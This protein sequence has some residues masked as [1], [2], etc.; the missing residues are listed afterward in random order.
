[1]R[2]QGGL[3][4]VFC[5]VLKWQRWQ[6]VTWRLWRRTGCHAHLGGG[7]WRSEDPAS[8][9]AGSGALPCSQEPSAWLSLFSILKPAS[10]WVLSSSGWPPAASPATSWRNSAFQEGL[11]MTLGPPKS[12]LL[13]TMEAVMRSR[14]SCNLACHKACSISRLISNVFGHDKGGLQCET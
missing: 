2:I 9:L 4:W 12:S 11:V 5:S 13:F 7:C 3:A 8:L 1:M 14:L 6:A 10:L